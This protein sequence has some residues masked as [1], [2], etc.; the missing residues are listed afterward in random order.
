MVLLREPSSATLPGLTY[1][2]SSG[3]TTTTRE[4]TVVRVWWRRCLL[5]ED[6]VDQD[7][8][9]LEENRPILAHLNM[10]INEEITVY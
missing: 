3:R 10:E 7:D 1:Y 2:D 4:T 9:R 5:V 8:P 6:E